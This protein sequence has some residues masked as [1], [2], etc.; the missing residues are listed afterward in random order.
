MVEAYGSTEV[1]QA[2]AEAQRLTAEVRS[3]SSYD[4]AKESG[5]LNGLSGAVRPVSYERMKLLCVSQ[6]AGSTPA[7]STKNA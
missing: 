4:E 5:S 6:H 3:P 2:R 1:I 7:V